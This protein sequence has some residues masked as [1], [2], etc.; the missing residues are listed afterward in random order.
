MRVPPNAAS[1]PLAPKNAEKRSEI[2]PKSPKFG[3]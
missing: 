1:N 2:E 3:A